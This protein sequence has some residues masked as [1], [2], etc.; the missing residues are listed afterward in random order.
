MIT[1]CAKLSREIQT[2]HDRHIQIMQA[3]FFL[4]WTFDASLSDLLLCQIRFNCKIADIPIC[5]NRFNCKIADILICQKCFYYIKIPDLA[6]SLTW[7]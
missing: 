3:V 4:V 1:N 2:W 7:L 5:E 6:K